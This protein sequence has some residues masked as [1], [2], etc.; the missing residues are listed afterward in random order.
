MAQLTVAPHLDTRRRSSLRRQ[1]WCRRGCLVLSTVTARFGELAAGALRCWHTARSPVQPG[2]TPEPVGI[3][4][5]SRCHLRRPRRPGYPLDQNNETGIGTAPITAPGETID[6][7]FHPARA[8]RGSTQGTRLNWKTRRAPAGPI[9]TATRSSV[10]GRP[11]AG[12]GGIRPACDWR[13]VVAQ[14]QTPRS[15]AWSSRLGYWAQVEGHAPTIDATLRQSY[16]AVLLAGRTTTLQRK[17]GVV[18]PPVKVEHALGPAT[19]ALEALE[20]HATLP[21]AP[22]CEVAP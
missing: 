1:P 21:P 11:G 18:S 10:Q 19:R 5:S 8:R 16:R 14:L 2:M 15:V 12:L 4:H 17:P 22:P 6:R 9:A 20:D 3:L 7:S 13:S